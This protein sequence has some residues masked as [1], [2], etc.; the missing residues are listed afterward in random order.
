MCVLGR[1]DRRPA[2]RRRLARFDMDAGGARRSSGMSRSRS[3]LTSTA[4]A[5]AI[6]RVAN[7]RMAGAI[8][9]VSIERGHDPRDFALLPFGGGGG[10]HAGALMREVGFDGA[11]IPRYP[12]VT[13][14][15]GLRHGRHAARL[16]AHGP[17][18]H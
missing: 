18:A 3:A 7:A 6:V 14:G 9:L 12:G 5:E 11:L 15:A 4:A 16:R 2:D 1:I 13:V 10:L 17:C 8:R